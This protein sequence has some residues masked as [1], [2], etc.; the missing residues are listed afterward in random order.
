MNPMRGCRKSVMAFSIG[1]ALLSASSASHASAIGEIIE[2]LIKWFAKTSDETVAA[3]P[4]IVRSVAKY[5]SEGCNLDL[6]DQELQIASADCL[7]EF[8]LMIEGSFRARSAPTAVDPSDFYYLPVSL[9]VN[10][11]GTGLESL[12]HVISGQKLDQRQISALKVLVGSSIDPNLAKDICAEPRLSWMREFGYTHRYITTTVDG[13]PVG[14]FIYDAATCQ[15]YL[16][17][18]G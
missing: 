13:E 9:K 8:L 17:V 12:S 7:K 6:E 4:E 14:D 11:A 1:F 3:R 10:A 16:E 15:E 5:Q 18:M 2:M